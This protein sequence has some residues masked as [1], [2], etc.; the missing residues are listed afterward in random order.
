MEFDKLPPWAQVAVGLP[1]LV[2]SAYLVIAKFFKEMR[3]PESRP[4]VLES[5]EL[6]DMNPVRALA[7]ALQRLYE[8]QSEIDGKLDRQIDV[9]SKI[10]DS[11]KEVVDL[12]QARAEAEKMALVRQ[13][14]REKQE[15]AKA[16]EIERAI[17]AD[18]ERRGS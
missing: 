10:A 16:D 6:A 18:R 12:L 1:L 2:V 7:P 5:A 3:R 9:Q 13:D 17:R 11:M 15:R 4:V 14:E 8:V